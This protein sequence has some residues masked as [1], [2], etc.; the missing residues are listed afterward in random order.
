MFRP[1]VVIAVFRNSGFATDNFDGSTSF[2]RFQNGD[3]LI[4]GEP[5]FTHGDLLRRLNQYDWTLLVHG[6]F[7]DLRR[8]TK[9]KK[10]TRDINQ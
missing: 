4:L 2:Y 7:P 10:T 3:V 5:D 1:P 6:G 9:F 8:S